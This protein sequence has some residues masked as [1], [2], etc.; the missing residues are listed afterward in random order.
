MAEAGFFLNPKDDKE[1]NVTCYSCGLEID[2][3]KK[4]DEPWY[5]KLMQ[6]FILTLI[7]HLNKRATHLKLRPDCKY[8]ETMGTSKH[9]LT[10][11]EFLEIERSRFQRINVK[12]SFS[13]IFSLQTT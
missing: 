8:M 10:V 3:M 11:F 13:T 12:T 2:N 5:I 1:E 6:I 9:N 4:T 7:A